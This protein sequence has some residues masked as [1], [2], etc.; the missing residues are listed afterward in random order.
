M[1]REPAY[2]DHLQ[3]LLVLERDAQRARWE[4]LRAQL[5]PAEQIA[6]GMALADLEAVDESWGLGGRLLVTLERPDRSDLDSPVDVGAPVAVRPRRGDTDESVS[7]VIAR[8]TRRQLVLAFDRPPP[9]F[10]AEGRLWIDLVSD[11]V[12]FSRARDAVRAV[13]G[14]ERGAQ[15]RKR[16]VLLG[17]EEARFDAVQPVQAQRPLNPEQ[18]DAVERA[19][20]AQDFFLV[21][22]PPGTGKS[23]VLGEI[24]VQAAAQGKRILAT[25]ASNAAV[26]HLLDLC[27]QRGLRALRIG[28]PARVAERLHEHTLDFRVEAMPDRKVARELLDEAFE[29][30]GYARKQRTRG[31]SRERFANARDAQAEA[32]R[33]FAEVRELEKR[34]V[35][36][37]LDSAQVICCTCT[38]LAGSTLRDERFDIALLD[39][40]T[41]AIEPLALLPFLKADR[42]I[43]AGDHC[44]L[45]PTV[46]SQEAAQL[47]LS[48]SLF[49]RL[50]AD[51]GD[52]VRR[53]LREQ[54]RMHE[55]IMAFASAEMYGGEL[56]AHPSVAARVLD[57]PGVDAPPVLFLDT[58]GKG[59]DEETPP[60]SESRCNPGEA[61]LV[62]A[63]LRELLEAGVPPDELAV[64]APYSA[65]VA[66]LRDLATRRGLPEAVE[67]DTVDAFQGREKD[68]ILFSLTRSNAD[69]QLGFLA[70]L[71]RMNVAITRPR[72]HLFV[73]GDS[74]TL[75][76]HPF[77]QRFLAYVEGRGG[78]RSAWEWPEPETAGSFS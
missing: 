36:A 66:L 21:H 49:E 28:H 29:L 32:K 5:T 67:I 62:L 14:M 9:P 41:Q 78:W 52:G 35:R 7:A 51:H 15:R 44:Q 68:A 39:E 57:V 26:D 31:R 72:K 58:A 74:A 76:H 11:E 53:M 60:G 65:Q 17:A 10:V 77:Y 55:A 23:T 73:V 46:I 63:R 43:L 37:V 50:L 30:Q 18:R 19:L 3:H 24:A 56:R 59:F 61:A 48:T 69:G 33:L 25:A 71:R 34:A 4:A 27:L 8:R 45:P 1:S 6:R 12:T 64:I 42:V 2:F 75:G 13:Q 47:G 16:G 54:Y 70:D 38:A 20:A 40:A 22:G